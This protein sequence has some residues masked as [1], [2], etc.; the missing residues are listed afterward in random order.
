MNVECIIMLTRA[1]LLTRRPGKSLG[2]GASSP[3]LSI[4]R[5]IRGDFQPLPAPGAF[6]P[7]LSIWHLTSFSLSFFSQVATGAWLSDTSGSFC[8]FGG[9]YLS[10]S[11]GSAWSHPQTLTPTLILAARV[12]DRRPCTPQCKLRSGWEVVVHLVWFSF[13]AQ[14]ICCYN[15]LT[16]LQ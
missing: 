2:S 11:P 1:E 8:P 3:S 9:T 16:T 7:S 14:R 10:P 6:R 12:R 5:Q 4:C 15:L 13:E